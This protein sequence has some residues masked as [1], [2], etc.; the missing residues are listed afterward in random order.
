MAENKTLTTLVRDITYYYIK[1]FYD[2]KLREENVTKIPNEEV[3]I[4]VN[5]MYHI[6]ESDLKKVDK[7]K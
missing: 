5:N 3:T 1:H 7:E 6:K 2:K 4:F